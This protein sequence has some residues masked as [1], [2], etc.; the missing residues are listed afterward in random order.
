MNFQFACGLQFRIFFN[1]VKI[2]N[3]INICGPVYIFKLRTENVRNDILKCLFG[4]YSEVVCVCARYDSDLNGRIIFSCFQRTVVLFIVQ[5]TSDLRMNVAHALKY[6][7]W[8][9]SN[10]L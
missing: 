10:L 7:S 5:N 2:R 8:R 1:G 9:T 6:A 3:R 4:L